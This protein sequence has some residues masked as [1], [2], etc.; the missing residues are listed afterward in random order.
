VIFA[1][2]TLKP[3]DDFNT[4]Q[5]YFSSSTNLGE[6]S[7]TQQTLQNKINHFHCGHIIPVSNLTCKI[8]SHYFVRESK[9]PYNFTFHYRNDSTQLK[10]LGNFLSKIHSEL[11]AKQ[12]NPSETKGIVV[13]LHSYEYKSF[14]LTQFDNLGVT[15]ALQEDSKV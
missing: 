14:L 12:P 15:E 6:G 13:F 5:G 10:A 3:L 7:Q 8:V 11:K 4:L 2:G 9:V 1:S